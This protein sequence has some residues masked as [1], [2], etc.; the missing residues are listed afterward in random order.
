[1][2]GELENTFFSLAEFLRSFHCHLGE[3]YLCS[4]PIHKEGFFQR[5]IKQENQ[6]QDIVFEISATDPIYS[7]YFST[8]FLDIT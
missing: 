3:D 2:C 4:R 8:S 5:Y 1:M 7:A 6:T